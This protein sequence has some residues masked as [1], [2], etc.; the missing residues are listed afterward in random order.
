MANECSNSV[1]ITGKT[2][3][4]Q[5]IYQVLIEENECFFRSF[6]PDPEDQYFRGWCENNWGTKWVSSV[7]SDSHID[8]D[9]D[10]IS[11]FLEFSTAWDPPIEAYETFSEANEQLTVE[12]S[13][14]EFGLG[15]F[16]IW[17]NEL[18]HVEPDVPDNLLE[19]LDDEDGEVRE[20]AW[21]EMEVLLEKE[22]EVRKSQLYD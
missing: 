13:F 3:D 17:T 22:K 6:I 19:D 18:G 1:T 10:E 12:A 4:M 2:A 11:I 15:R 9:A 20:N 21:E 14:N 16:G 7:C 5:K 8:E